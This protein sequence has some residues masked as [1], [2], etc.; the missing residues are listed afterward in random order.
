[1]SKDT[2]EKMPKLSQR[3]KVRGGDDHDESIAPE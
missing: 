1:M 3:G 2:L